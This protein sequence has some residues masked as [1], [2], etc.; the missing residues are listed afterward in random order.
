MS[1][2]RKFE[3]IKLKNGKKEHFYFKNFF[4]PEN[5]MIFKFHY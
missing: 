3:D 4:K 5:E 2:I 1:F